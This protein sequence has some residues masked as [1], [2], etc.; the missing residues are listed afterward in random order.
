MSAIVNT[1]IAAAPGVVLAGATGG[2]YLKLV[3][4]SAALAVGTSIAAGAITGGAVA[5]A[6]NDAAWAPPVGLSGMAA[7]AVA[8][9]AVLYASTRNAR[10]T[11][12]LGLWALPLLGG[13][14]AL[15]ASMTGQQLRDLPDSSAR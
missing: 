12:Y 5:A 6:R 1:T 11:A 7:G 8:G 3:G 13:L 10:T 4:K 9:S 2:V 15:S 14:G